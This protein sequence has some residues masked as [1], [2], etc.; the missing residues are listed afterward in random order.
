MFA[1]IK[2]TI[3]QLHD[4]EFEGVRFEMSRINRAIVFRNGFQAFEG[5]QEECLL[6]MKGMRCMSLNDREFAEK[7]FKE[8]N[9]EKNDNDMG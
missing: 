5:T 9:G 2:T 7:R 8:L 1:I 3:E 4:E 6:F